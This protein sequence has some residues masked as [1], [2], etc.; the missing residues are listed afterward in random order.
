MFASILL[1]V[2][3]EHLFRPIIVSHGISHRCMDIICVK[4]DDLGLNLP[5]N[6]YASGTL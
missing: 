5:L 6:I 3:V 2:T 4:L 1:A